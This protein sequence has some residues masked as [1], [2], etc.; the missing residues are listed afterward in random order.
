MPFGRCGCPII[1]V[2]NPMSERAD[3]ILTYVVLAL[4]FGYVAFRSITRAED[5]ARTGFKWVLTVVVVVFIRW[6]AFPMADQGG[7]AA[8]SALALSM[9]GGLVLFITWRQDIGSLVAKPFASLYDGGNVPVDPHPFYS[10]ARARQ[11]QG[12]YTEAIAE[13]HKQ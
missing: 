12:K 4:A 7:M 8:F 6:K 3:Q 5:P 1:D 2:S 9:V 13:I 11:K 10:I